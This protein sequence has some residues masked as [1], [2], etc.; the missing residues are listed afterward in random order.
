MPSAGKVYAMLGNETLWDVT[1]RCGELLNKANIPYAVCGG[2]AVCLHGY[3]R[4]TVDLDLIVRREDATAMRELLVDAGWRWDP[5]AAEFRTAEG[6]A[7]HVLHAGEKAG[8]DSQ[9]L[10]ADPAGEPNVEQLE[11]LGVVRLSRLIEMKLAS[12]M[13]SL[14]RTHKDFADVVELIAIRELDG[15]FGRFL[16]PSVRDTFRQLRRH[17]TDSGSP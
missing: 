4:N 16:H 15:T 8:R 2:V 3:Q 5:Q 9:V 12:G 1:I 14:R 13:T 6:I 11:G 10:I 17:A 7:V